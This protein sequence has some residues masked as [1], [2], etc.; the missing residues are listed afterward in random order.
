MRK[1]FLAISLL[2]ILIGLSGCDSSSE[3]TKEKLPRKLSLCFRDHAEVLKM[4]YCVEQKL[5]R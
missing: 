3:V 5:Q 1:L 4:K 2:A